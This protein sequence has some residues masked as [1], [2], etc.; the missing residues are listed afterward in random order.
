MSLLQLYKN[1]NIYTLPL[2]FRVGL[3]WM[4]KSE[5][6]P[7]WIPFCGFPLNELNSIQLSWPTVEACSKKHYYIMKRCLW[8][9]LMVDFVDSNISFMCF[10]I[11]QT[12]LYYFILFSLS[13]SSSLSFH[14]ALFGRFRNISSFSLFLFLIT[15][16]T[17]I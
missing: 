17:I 11:I 10:T 16:I 13:I 8:L 6:E 2:R 12:S 1:L 14:F 5:N 15:L 7:L 9:A 3:G 4:G